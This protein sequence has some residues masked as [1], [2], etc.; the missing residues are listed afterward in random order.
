MAGSGYWRRWREGVF[1]TQSLWWES[2]S[3]GAGRSASD[4]GRAVDSR[5]RGNDGF[6][7]EDG[8]ERVLGETARGYG[9]DEWR[10]GAR[11]GV[12]RVMGF[13]PTT[14]CLGS[15]YSTTELHPH[16]AILG[17]AP[18]LVKPH[19]A[20]PGFAETPRGL[21][22]CQGRLVKPRPARPGFAETRRWL[23]ICR[24]RLAR[25]CSTGRGLPR[26]LAF[27]DPPRGSPL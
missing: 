3:R 26:S 17:H 24:G 9:G 15:R 11:A 21:P 27:V 23:P 8:G 6:G 22:I 10:W 13:E 12:E 14:L 19:P 20:R 1:L 16:S 5:L 7:C 25:I 4:G 2:Q 18:S